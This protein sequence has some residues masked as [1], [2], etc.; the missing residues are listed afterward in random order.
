MPDTW[1]PG[2]IVEHRGGRPV[3]TWLMCLLCVAFTAA[4]HLA[5]LGSGRQWEEIGRLGYLPLEAIWSGGYTA[6]F[7]SVFVHGGLLHLVFNVLWLMALGR[8]LEETLNPVAWAAFFIAAAV[9]ASGTE[10]AVSGVAPIGVSGVVYAMFG[11]VW[12]GRHRVPAWRLLATRGNFYLMVGWGIFAM[13]ATWLHL[14]RVASAAHFGG[15]LFG[16][17]VG[18]L[19]VER[20]RLVVSVVSVVA[21]VGLVALTVASV[22]WMPWS[23]GWTWWKGN[24]TMSEGHYDEA[25]SWYRRSVRLGTPPAAYWTRVLE[26]AMQRKDEEGAKQALRELMRLGAV[27][28]RPAAPRS[29]ATPGAP[30]PAPGRAAD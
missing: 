14:L 23:R 19:F 2:E 10:I 28:L 29:P 11:L 7:T 17:S 13:V 12:A 16:L 30:G 25:L 24:D 15:F 9:I 18:W 6:L 1:Q 3:L 26:I 5:P 22:T 8:L 4:V 21:I 27:T 20:R